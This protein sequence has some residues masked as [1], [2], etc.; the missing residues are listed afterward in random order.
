M[1]TNI[2]HF[3]ASCPPKSVYSKAQMTP[4]EMYLFHSAF[5][6]NILLKTIGHPPRIPAI[7]F[8]CHFNSIFP[9]AETHCLLIQV[10]KKK[11]DIVKLD[12]SMKE[13]ILLVF[14]FK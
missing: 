10:K 5:V 6:M 12:Q 4:K 1:A 2:A 8:S 13:V 3:P 9:S 7:K 14:V 11:K